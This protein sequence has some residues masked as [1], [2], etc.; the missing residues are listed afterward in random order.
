LGIG[1]FLHILDRGDEL[2][3][4]IDLMNFGQFRLRRRSALVVKN[5]S[6]RQGYLRQRLAWQTR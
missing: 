1:A 5:I 4:P 6:S 3:I 2:H